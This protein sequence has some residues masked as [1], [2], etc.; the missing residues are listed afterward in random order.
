MNNFAKQICV[1]GILSL[2]ACGGEQDHAH[3]EGTAAHAHNGGDAHAHDG[4]ELHEHGDG[5]DSHKAPETEAFYGDEASSDDAA[6][7]D[8]S[9]EMH[10]HG[11]GE[12]HTH[13]D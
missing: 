8:P 12:L 7:S 13:D 10:D 11:D 2:T 4:D 5:S 1:L 9:S 3:E 6:S